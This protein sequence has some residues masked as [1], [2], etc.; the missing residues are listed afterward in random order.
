MMP[1]VRRAFDLCYLEGILRPK[2]VYV[3]IGAHRARFLAESALLA[4]D[5]MYLLYEPSP[6]AAAYLR[7]KFEHVVNVHVHQQAVSG[8]RTSAELF[9]D[10]D[11]HKGIG[12]TLFPGVL[13]DAKAI[14]VSVV[15]LADVLESNQIDRIRLLAI[16]AEQAEY[17]ILRSPPVVLERVDYIT[18]EF[19]PGKSGVDT[20]GFI[21]KHLPQFETLALLRCGEPYNIWLGRSRVC[22]D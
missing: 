13:A 4:P 20:L 18:C 16:N 8:D 12:N 7:K 9:V 17:E 5:K 19:H 15:S 6:A 10:D 21:E 2:D 22:V 3:E 14:A 11:Y 1:N